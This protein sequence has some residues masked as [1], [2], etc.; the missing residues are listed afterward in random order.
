MRWVSEVERYCATVLAAVNLSVSATDSLP[1]LVL[2]AALPD[3]TSSAM[4]TPLPPSPA[5]TS[6]FCALSQRGRDQ[7]R[8]IVSA[9]ASTPV[10]RPILIILKCTPMY[11]ADTASEPI[12]MRPG[13]HMWFCCRLPG[14][15]NL[16][17][18]ATTEPRQP[19]VLACTFLLLRLVVP[20]LLETLGNR[21]EGPSIIASPI[22]G[23][24]GNGQE[25]GMH[26]IKVVQKLANQG[27]YVYIT[28]SVFPK[29]VQ[30]NNLWLNYQHY[31]PKH[32]SRRT[33]LS[34][35][36]SSPT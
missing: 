3:A 11:Q 32:P 13:T 15:S 22:L 1:P 16:A 5:V 4:E 33:V 7:V 20:A 27:A 34:K 17:T 12:Q 30:Y 19:R 25:S 29:F 14:F 6:P 21:N 23:P 26:V 28:Y 36:P 31:L 24:S 2:D 10:P 9:F 8:H 35:M 18:Q